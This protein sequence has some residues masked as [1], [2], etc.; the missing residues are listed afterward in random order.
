MSRGRG[1]SVTRRDRALLLHRAPYGET[2]LVVEVLSPRFGPCSLLARGAYRPTS[3]F[4]AV[5]DLFDTL[6][7]EWQER[8][9]SELGL[10]RAG[11][12]EVL[13][14]PISRDLAAYR[15]GLAA[16]DSL[17][18]AARPGRGEPEL[19][20]L[21]ERLFDSLARDPSAADLELAAF[22]LAFLEHLGLSPALGSCASCGRQAPASGPASTAFSAMLG[23][24]LCRACAE[25]AR[26]EGARVGM[27]GAE[28]LGAAALLATR[29]PGRIDEQT[30]ET[31][32]PERGRVRDFVE[33]F[34]EV[35]L[36]RRPKARRRL[37]RP[38]VRGR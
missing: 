3:R 17:R 14:T 37:P 15:A 29:G 33:R 11:D 5:L 18:L 35:H 13:R 16:L 2:S 25:R 21:A 8:R 28:T 31:L 38:A 4:F 36:E 7:L 27:L 1:P 19:F 10:L 24:R 32:E 26:G 6:D 30:R 34:L 23:G 12:R 22:D 9:G 20:A